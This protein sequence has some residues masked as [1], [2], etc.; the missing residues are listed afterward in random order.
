[1]I[2]FRIGFLN[3]ITMSSLFSTRRLSSFVVLTVLNG[4][5]ALPVYP[6]LFSLSADDYYA[7]SADSSCRGIALDA[8][9]QVHMAGY[10]RSPVFPCRNAYQPSLSGAVDAFVAALSSSGSVLLYATY[11]GGRGEDRAFGIAVDGEGGAVVSGVTSSADFPIREAYQSEPGG[12]LDAFVA[13]IASS[14]SE[15]FYATYLGGKEDDAAFDIAR[16]SSGGIYVSGETLSENFPTRKPCQ[17]SKV[18][19]EQD[20]FLTLFTSDLSGVIFST[21][22]GGRGV[23]SGGRIDLDPAGSIYVAGSTWSEDFPTRAAYSSSKS[24]KYDAFVAKLDPSAGVLVYSTYLGS[25]EIDFAYDLAVDPEGGALI[26]GI[27]LGE[28]FPEVF[29]LFERRAEEG[30]AF[31]TR[32]SPSGSALSFSTC[33]GTPEGE[34][35]LVLESDRKGDVYVAGFTGS[36]EFPLRNP[37]QT[38]ERGHGDAFITKLSLSTSS[39]VYSTYLGG[40][41]IDLPYGLAVDSEGCLYVA[42]FT[43][44]RDFPLQ[45]PFQRNMRGDADGFITGF[46]SSGSRLLFSTFLGGEFSR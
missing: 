38:R 24:G 16:N 12:K 13:Y 26:T 8:S 46:S 2:K 40:N 21:Y 36:P 19:W 14:G 34:C 20:V 33:W 29:P 39:I 10:T 18:G 3:F 5:Y 37:F 41:E 15:L 43:R 6:Q 4:I 9:G 17:A 7:H 11:L 30:T 45:H 44:S 31:L 1:M 23:D 32:I 42:G 25:K 27:T 28:D 35:G 22:L